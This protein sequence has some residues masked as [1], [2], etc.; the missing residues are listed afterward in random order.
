M[1]DRG[2]LRRDLGALGDLGEGSVRQP[3]DV[4]RGVHAGAAV[5]EPRGDPLRGKLER[6]ASAAEE[7]LAASILSAQVTAS[8]RCAGGCH[9]QPWASVRAMKPA[10]DGAWGSKNQVGACWR[11]KMSRSAGGWNAVGW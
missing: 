9:F 3:V 10:H 2:D 6:D 7:N 5:R 4:A 1:L 11:S 8:A